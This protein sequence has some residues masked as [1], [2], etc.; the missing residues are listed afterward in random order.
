M[1]RFI[2]KKR[3]NIAFAA[4]SG[5]AFKLV[6]LVHKLNS[7]INSEETGFLNNAIPGLH[8][9]YTRKSAK[10]IKFGKY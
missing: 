9:K 4:L 3:S 8:S 5:F 1:D 10:V 7:G 6:L 2:H